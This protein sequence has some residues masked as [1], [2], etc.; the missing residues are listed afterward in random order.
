MLTHRPRH[1]PNV[2]S[3][4]GYRLRR[5]HIIEPSFGKC[6]VLTG[7]S[8]NDLEPHVGGGGGGGYT[9]HYGCTWW[10]NMSVQ[11]LSGWLIAVNPLNI[12]NTEK[13]DN[14]DPAKQKYWTLMLARVQDGGLTLQR[15]RLN[16]SC[17]CLICRVGY[18]CESQWIRMTEN[19]NCIINLLVFC[20]CIHDIFCNDKSYSHQIKYPVFALNFKQLWNSLCFPFVPCQWVPC[21]W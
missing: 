18:T 5:W 16:F 1:R 3:M 8:V 7:S 10:H 2:G 17:F 21:I 4:L 12:Q 13:A 19:F 14:F 15:H 20:N 11:P 9:D 6:L